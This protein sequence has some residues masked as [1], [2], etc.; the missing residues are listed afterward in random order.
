MDIIQQHT[1][2]EDYCILD[3]I[4][5]TERAYR[6][7]YF[8]QDSYGKDYVLTIYDIESTPD[9]LKTKIDGKVTINEFEWRSRLENTNKF[10]RLA[11]KGITV[12]DGKSVA[13]LCTDFVESEPLDV[14]IQKH[15]A[16]EPK[17]A[18]TM[19]LDILTSI[20]EASLVT[21]GGGHFNLSPDNLMVYSDEDGHTQLM[22]V[23]WSHLSEPCNGKPL[24][25]TKELNPLYR[26]PET[27][28]GRF[29][30]QADVFS[31]GVIL[32]YMITGRSP[33]NAS[34]LELKDTF[35]KS[36]KQET[37][38]LQGVDSTMQVIIRS[39]TA[40]SRL[41]RYRSA[42]EFILKLEAYIGIEHRALKHSVEKVSVDKV[43]TTDN[44]DIIK[45]AMGRPSSTITIGKIS[46]NGYADVAGMESLKTVFRRNFIDIV[47]HIEMAKQFQ[48]TP[49]NS[50]LLYGPPGVGKTFIVQK[51]AEEAGLNY[52]L[53]KPSD[54]SSIY[55]HGSQSMIADVFQKAEKMAPV[56]LCFDE[57]DAMVPARTADDKN[58]M[59]G[60]INEFLTQLNNC[61]E[62]GIYVMGTTNR[63]DRIDKAI[64]RKGRFDELIYVPLPDFEARKSMF[65]IELGKRPH[66]DS[67]NYERLASM[68]ES[69]SSCDIAYIV[70][71][72]ARTSFDKSI[73][74]SPVNIEPIDEMLLES[75]ISKTKPSVSKD[76]LRR[77]EQMEK[78]L[79]QRKEDL[80]PRIGF[81]D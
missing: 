59:G 14:Y 8:A 64:L 25:N 41:K 29:T 11:S 16:I 76:D 77:Y 56:L 67:V 19:M 58:N 45:E 60:E 52:T 23:G 6:Q 2:I 71:E 66:D 4:C 27:I 28:I 72:A 24:F 57:F 50:S 51:T 34:G 30:Q 3:S 21:N 44:T 55:I 75:I 7:L 68:T 47:K 42:K 9:D 33:W 37:L 65:E 32:A 36:M 20:H 15:G 22:L 38:Q 1:K 73:H 81:L 5:N 63:P 49:P 74:T 61:A 35:L 79:S 70:K 62:R 43:E 39:T 53:V 18:A 10:P 31:L 54:I 40:K 26:A 80:R 46:G 12:V 69:Y 78:E 17:L 13:W 48:I